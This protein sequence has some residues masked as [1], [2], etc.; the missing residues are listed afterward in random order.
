LAAGALD[1]A[2]LKRIL[3]RILPKRLRSSLAYRRLRHRLGIAVEGRRV[4]SRPDKLVFVVATARTGSR[5]LVSYL[6][7]VPGVRLHYEVLNPELKTGLRRRFVSKRT[8]LRHID[9][10]V[11]TRDA[12]VGGAKFLLPQLSLHRI[13][14]DDLHRAYPR[15]TFII[16]YRRSLAEQFVSLEI[17][18]KTRQWHSRGEEDGFRG[19]VRIDID[20][21][22][23]FANQVREYY[24][25]ALSPP[26]IREFSI[27]VSYEELAGDPQ[28][29]FDEGIFPFLGIPP[30]RVVT[31]LHKSNTRPLEEVVANY[32]EVAHVL[33]GKEA[34]LELGTAG[35]Q[36]R[37]PQPDR[38]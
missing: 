12:R 18:A 14:L 4:R 11:R 30:T 32:E 24:G 7:N 5:L 26:W 34:K 22:R 15:S 10:S 28:R 19:F 2:Q 6:N 29:L 37:E 17:A 33:A 1:G 16:L 25:S 9:H 21:F 20:K 31:D 27:L 23:R 3:E 35:A 38:R 13:S 36:P 8:V